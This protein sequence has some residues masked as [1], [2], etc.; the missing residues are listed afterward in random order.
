MHFS[1]CNVVCLLALLVITFYVVVASKTSSTP[2]S[3]YLQLQNQRAILH[4]IISSLT[5]SGYH[6]ERRNI[7][8]SHTR[9]ISALSHE[10]YSLSLFTHNLKTRKINYFW[11]GSTYY[12]YLTICMIMGL[13]LMMMMM[14]VLLDGTTL[15][16]LS[17][18]LSLHV[19]FSSYNLT[20]SMQPSLHNMFPS[21]EMFQEESESSFLEWCRE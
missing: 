18:S 11:I 4:C 8:P 12:T 21:F 2:A 1:F 19:F 17:L 16:N 7:L 9:A 20:K 5:L 15:E 13:L 14:I 3:L 10:C 6:H